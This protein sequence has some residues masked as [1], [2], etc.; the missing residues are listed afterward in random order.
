MIKTIESLNIFFFRKIKKIYR[1]W[2]DL[3]IPGPKPRFLIGN[4]LDIIRNSRAEIDSKWARQY[5]SIYGYYMGVFPNLVITD[6]ELVKQVFVKDFPHFVNR[7]R[8]NAYHEL[9]NT[10]LLLAEDEDWK[11]IRYCCF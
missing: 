8:L 3:G 10:N 4:G 2:S 6:P 5:G 1:T 11:R 7:L 9:W